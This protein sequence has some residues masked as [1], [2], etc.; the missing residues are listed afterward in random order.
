M[1]NKCAS[2]SLD[3][4]NK[5]SYLKTHGDEGWEEYP[6]Y[7]DVVVPRVLQLLDKVGL[8]ITFFIVG[9]D[10]ERPENH[11][12]LRSIVEA[13]HEIGNHSYSH[14]PWLHL[15][16]PSEIEAELIRTEDA[17]EAATGVRPVGFR[18]PGYSCS[19]ELLSTL[20]QRGYLFDASKLPTFIGPL[21][22]AYYLFRS[23]LGK[24]ER[25]KREQL[26]G[27]LKEGFCPIKPFFWEL[28]ESDPSEQPPQLLEIPVTTMPFFRVPF[29]F[30]YLHYIGQYSSTLAWMYWK[31]SLTLCRAT[32]VEPSLLLHPLD[33]MDAE[34]EPSLAFFP[35]MKV[36]AEEKLQFLERTLTE[37][38]GAYQI[39]PMSRHAQSLMQRKNLKIRRL[40]PNQGGEVSRQEPVIPLDRKLEETC[41]SV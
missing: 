28:T 9:R 25:Q 24:E 10:A 26:F 29:H 34:D 1:A 40:A 32:G 12:A 6:S 19:P 36:P 14:E 13:G 23:D 7:L 11:A 37:F 31:T 8:R 38:A 41:S 35:G 17:L 2:L 3:L 16:K 5:W 27:S 20:S 4:D 22:R 15:Y 18:G 33:F 21:A 39:L 30:S